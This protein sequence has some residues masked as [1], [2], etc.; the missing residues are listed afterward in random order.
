MG[1]NFSTAFRARLE[2]GSISATS[3]SATFSSR[4][5]LTRGVRPAAAAAGGAAAASSFFFLSD[6]ASASSNRSTSTWQAPKLPSGSLSKK[7][8]RQ[9]TASVS[10]LRVTACSASGRAAD[11]VRLVLPLTKFCSAIRATP[12]DTATLRA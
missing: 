6:S 5:C 2:R 12:L 10:E 11:S 9:K 8:V 4:L 3:G 1:S 7:A